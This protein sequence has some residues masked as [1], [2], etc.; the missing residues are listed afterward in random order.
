MTIVGHPF[1][2][3]RAIPHRDEAKSVHSD[4]S[5]SKA[6]SDRQNSYVHTKKNKILPCTV[7]GD[8]VYCIKK[9]F[10]NYRRLLNGRDNAKRNTI[11]TGVG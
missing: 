5:S 3:G 10:A 11:F 8:S 4:K 9:D 7:E 2:C 1:L 6:Q